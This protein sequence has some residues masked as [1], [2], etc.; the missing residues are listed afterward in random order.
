MFISTDAVRPSAGAPTVEPRRASRTVNYRAQTHRRPGLRRSRPNLDGTDIVPYHDCMERN[1]DRDE[2]RSDL[3]GDD[4]KGRQYLGGYFLVSETELM[5]PNFYRT[6][7]LMIDHNDDGAFGLVVNRPSRMPLSAVLEDLDELAAGSIPVYIGGPVEQQY[8]FVLHSGIEA[9]IELEHQIEVVPSVYF[10]PLTVPLV[11]YLKTT[12]SEA[13]ESDRPSIHI[14]A[15][16]SGWGPGQL[17]S[18]L[19]QRAWVTIEAT[20]DIVF[21]PNPDEGWRNALGRK[22]EFYRIVAE[23]G[24]KP[25]LN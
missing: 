8:L 1:D 2:D 5:D 20:E 12:W 15:G 10:H 25:S 13:R 23:T 16:Y 3:Q 11:E 7:V 22:S 21:D 4:G 24:F 9:E 17:E 6:V 18:E 14:F 19:G